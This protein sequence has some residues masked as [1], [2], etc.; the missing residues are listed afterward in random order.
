MGQT[1]KQK[2]WLAGERCFTLKDHNTL[3]VEI[4]RLKKRASYALDIAVLKPKPKHH[5]ALAKKSM[6]AM[7]VSIVLAYVLLYIPL[8]DQMPALIQQQLNRDWLLSSFIIIGLVSFIL[9]LTFTQYERVFVARHT[10]LPLVRMFNGLPDKQTFAA[11]TDSLH[12]QSQKRFDSLELSGQKQRAGEL[13]TIRRLV[14]A[15]VL[16]QAQY[17]H[18]KKK[19][20]K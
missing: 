2:K 20:L 9:F 11:F 18:A 16:S 4:K 19:L 10:Q 15:G 7:F 12:Q 8:I 14:D 3:V 6:L 17:N 1:L 13:K 5:F